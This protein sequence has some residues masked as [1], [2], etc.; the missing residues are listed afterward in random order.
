[1]MVGHNPGLEDL[2]EF[3]AGSDSR[4]PLELGFL[5]TAAVAH[6]QVPDAWDKLQRGTATLTRVMTPKS[7]PEPP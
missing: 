7:L 5:K 1:M 4:A 3:L 2:V 6:L